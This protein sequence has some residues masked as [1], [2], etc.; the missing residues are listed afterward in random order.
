MSI[1]VGGRYRSQVGTTEIIV[2]RTPSEDADL[3]CGGLP[4]IALDQTPSASASPAPG[5][6]ETT[7]VGKR[8]VSDNASLEI[9]V[10]KSG[11]GTLTLDGTPLALA[12]MKPLPSSD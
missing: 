4:V 1:Q 8:Y 7:L 12:S 3:A 10:T 6:D 11:V 5:L 2:V 9:L